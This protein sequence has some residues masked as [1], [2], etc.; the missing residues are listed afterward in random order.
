[1]AKIVAIRTRPPFSQKPYSF[2]THSNVIHVQPVVISKPRSFS[3]CD[4]FL[5]FDRRCII[6]LRKVLVLMT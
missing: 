3:I 6:V 4:V 2:Y 5:T 1:L